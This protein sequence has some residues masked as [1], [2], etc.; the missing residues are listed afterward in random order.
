M[1]LLGYRCNCADGGSL[2]CTA[3]LRTTHSIADEILFLTL[4][5]PTPCSKG[6]ACRPAHNIKQSDSAQTNGIGKLRVRFDTALY[7]LRKRLGTRH[8]RLR[9]GRRRR[10]RIMRP[11]L[12]FLKVGAPYNDSAVRFKMKSAAFCAWAAA[13]ITSRLSLRSFASNQQES[14]M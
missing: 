7:G 9:P 10:G 4:P 5:I 11:P 13:I 8:F 2:R 12:G 3:R 6:K 14:I 1:D